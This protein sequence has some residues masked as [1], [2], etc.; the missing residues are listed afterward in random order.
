ME[1]LLSQMWLH[2]QFISLSA[3]QIFP[4]RILALFGERGVDAEEPQRGLPSRSQCHALVGARPAGV[5]FYE[6]F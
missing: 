3:Y 5:R 4:K 1:T 6:F 2:Y